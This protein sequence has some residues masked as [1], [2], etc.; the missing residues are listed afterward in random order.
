MCVGVLEAVERVYPDLSS[1]LTSA[2]TMPGIK[3]ILGKCRAWMR[4]SL[5]SKSIAE[6]FKSIVD[7]KQQLTDWYEPDAI[8]FTEDA[9]VIAGLLQSLNALDYN[10]TREG[11]EFDADT[12]VIDFSMYLKD[13]NYLAR[14]KTSDT[15][16][17]PMHNAAD[18]T[19]SNEFSML[20]DQK[21]Y[22]EELNKKLQQELSQANAV[23]EQQG[24]SIQSRKR[25]KSDLE[26]KLDNT[27][28]ELSELRSI[29]ESA[30]LVC[31]YFTF[32]C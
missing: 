8:M 16:C 29:V 2:K 14:P 23:I 7:S 24:L 6:D 26:G 12:P 27:V 15:K 13:G 28:K 4:L 30:S 19:S 31:D 22:L 32:T 17:S 1:N 11:A 18:S 10:L 21:A 20:L 25:E 5:M 9:V 3:T